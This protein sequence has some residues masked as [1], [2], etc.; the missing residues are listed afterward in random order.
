MK[1]QFKKLE[2]DFI[3]FRENIKKVPNKNIPLKIK[4]RGEEPILK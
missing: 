2:K 4:R 3:N 1:E